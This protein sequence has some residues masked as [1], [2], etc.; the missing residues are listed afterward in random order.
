M[1]PSGSRPR[2]PDESAALVRATYD[3]EVREYVHDR[4]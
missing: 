3:E 4:W 1:P 2:L